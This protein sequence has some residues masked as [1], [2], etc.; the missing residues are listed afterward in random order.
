M[1]LDHLPDL[2]PNHATNFIKTDTGFLS[3]WEMVH[4]RSAIEPYRLHTLYQ[5]AVRY[6]SVGNFAEVGVYRGGSAYILKQL[7][8]HK[9]YLFDTFAGMPPVN[10]DRD[11]HHTGD[12]NDT[13]LED[14]QRF[15]GLDEVEYCVGTFPQS[16]EPRHKDLT[17][18]FVHVDVDIYQSTLDCIDFFEPRLLPGGVMIFDDFGFWTC[19]GSRDAVLNRLGSSVV[20]LATGQCIYIKA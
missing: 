8:R 4:N 5:F 17:F 10:P 1:N 11:L 12:F 2:L 18:A 9:T 15:V 20:Y 3:F 6:A 14:V 16:L 19:P 13:S 7:C